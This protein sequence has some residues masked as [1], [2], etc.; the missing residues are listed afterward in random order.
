MLFY[1]H[2]PAFSPIISFHFMTKIAIFASGS[3]TNAQ[4]IIQT[5]GGSI[6]VTAV[7]CNNPSAG[8]IGRAQ[9]LGVNVFL[10]NRV[11]LYT[12]GE[13]LSHILQSGAEYIVLAGFLW[14]I[15]AEMIALFPD[16]IINIHPA[17]L[18]GYGGK[19]MYGD[20]VHKA[21]IANKEQESGITIHLVNERYDEGRYLLQAKCPVSEHDTPESLAKAVHNLEYEY[22]PKTILSYIQEHKKKEL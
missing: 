17:L 10:F 22:F 4:N 8:V 18:P 14:L 1:V 6:S 11:Q 3:G 15:P 5:L 12:S 2:L 13:V 20:N 19:G 7:Y 9:S 16:R 21:V